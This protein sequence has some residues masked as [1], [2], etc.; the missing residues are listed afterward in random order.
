MIKIED[1]T[2]AEAK[3]RIKTLTAQL[4][5]L[6][7]GLT[8]VAAE[9]LSSL[10]SE[11]NEVEVELRNIEQ[12]VYKCVNSSYI[13]GRDVHILEKNVELLADKIAVIEILLS[14]QDLSQKAKEQL[15][16]QL[17]TLFSDKIVLE[18]KLTE[19]YNIT[20]IKGE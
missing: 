15:F 20:T 9:Q 11:Y 19:W 16:S 8:F 18:N 7:K 13:E 2:L 5:V 10:I 14:R 6:R 12:L 3:S 4:L 1:I 17:K